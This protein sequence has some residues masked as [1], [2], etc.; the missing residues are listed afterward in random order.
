[1]L[2]VVQH[3]PVKVPN[4]KLKTWKFAGKF[5][6]KN[7]TV[8]NKA[9]L[10]RWTK[11]ELLELGPTF[12]KLGQIASTRGDLY[13]PEFTKELESLQD[14][15]PP[16]EFDTSV[17]YDIFK[18]FDPVPFK[19]A[20]IGQVHMAVLQNGQKVVV[21]L[22]R[23]GILDIM[24]EDTDTIRDIVHFLERVGIDTGNSSGYVLEESIEYL[25]GE[26]DYQQEID[27][28]VEF[29]KSMRDVEWVKVPKVYK[30]YSNDE[31][32]VMEYVPSTKL[33]EITDKKVNKKK[34]CEA[35]INSYVIQTMDNGLFHA[36]P[37]PGNLGFSSR[38][39]LVFYD[40]GLL[41]RLSEELRGG[42]KKLFGYI[43]TRDTAGIVTVLIELGV[44]V[45][46]T[47]DVSDIEM[48]FE[49]ILGYLETLDGSGIMNDDLAVQLAAE[50]PFVVP[51]SFVYLAKSFSIIEGI[52]LQLD[53][54]FNYFTY[55]EPMIQQQFIESFDVND[56]FKRT[57]EIPAKIG[58]ISSTVMGL[59]K[60][61]SAMKRSMI[62]TQREIKVVQYSVVCA[63]LAERFGDTP[64]AMVF[65]LC[66]LWFTFRKNR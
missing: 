16:V 45:P 11:E 31:M 5:L 3:V 29:R 33:T 27:N 43:I 19:S 38:G 58:K 60:S 54:E 12:V 46:T 15:V 21:K 24:K 50:K 53:P 57:S 62:K 7:A 36:D 55:L 25:L 28:A 48:F 41:V 65:V 35:L 10:G 26:A 23:P 59:E 18:E 39:K 9:E 8:Q 42:F 63:L 37:H 56:V 4:R 47:S 40:F 44:I 13:P 30:K 1:M 34:I 49:T 2:C 20:S 66:T 6:W 51:T 52:C 14:N 61:R 22:K 64:L 32:I 17:K